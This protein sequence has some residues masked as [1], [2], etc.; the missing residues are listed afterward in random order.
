MSTMP[1]LQ[2]PGRA[3]GL[4]VGAI[5]VATLCS[6]CKDYA[7]G[8]LSGDGGMEST[9]S[10]PG[11]SDG[12]GC[13]PC[14]SIH[15]GVDD[16]VEDPRIDGYLRAV[17]QFR[18]TVNAAEIKFQVRIAALANSWNYDG[19]ITPTVENVTALAAFVESEL[20]K[21]TQ[22]DALV[23]AERLRCGAD[24]A[25]AIEE[26][27][28][29]EAD[30]GC[31]LDDAC[32]D[33]LTPETL[34]IRCDGLCIGACDG[35]CEGL[36]LCDAA[37]TLGLQCPG[38]CFGTCEVTAEACD[39]K[40]S[41]QCDTEDS[42][43]GTCDGLCTGD[44]TVL[45]GTTC[46]GQC[47]GSC[48]GEA[49]DSVCPTPPS[50][51]VPCSAA[52]DGI[53]VGQP[54]PAIGGTCGTDPCNAVGACNPT[55]GMRANVGLTCAPVAVQACV[56]PLDTLSPEQQAEFDERIEALQLGLGALLGIH[57][58]L[59]LVVRGDVDG[60]LVEYPQHPAPAEQLSTKIIGL[61]QAGSPQAACPRCAHV[62]LA[63]AVVAVT[64]TAD[65]AEA[66]VVVGD[67]LIEAFGLAA[68]GR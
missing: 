28:R 64:S 48:V 31:A 11:T 5:C 56:T 27:A 33:A 54:E 41:G 47:K 59:A 68:P 49:L 15:D 24:Q 39:G 38:T 25:L 19:P 13:G 6:G 22:G 63:E 32:V 8:S 7:L 4:L 65:D 42:F 20:A 3:R 2:Q 12:G 52:C 61:W 55:S 62:A 44:C 29:C 51:I 46:S 53:C 57:A 18:E 60:M 1:R 37:D 34:D 26:Q 21:S 16:I 40:C 43:V 50:C 9:S 10:A 45:S 35:P 17:L 36:A 67:A 66:L 14:V 58:E 23:H 30:L